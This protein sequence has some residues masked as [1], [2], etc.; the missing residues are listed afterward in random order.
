MRHKNAWNDVMPAVKY[1][2]CSGVMWLVACFVVVALLVAETG[3]LKIYN[4]LIKVVYRRFVE[5]D[6]VRLLWILF[7]F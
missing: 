5:L 3:L 7:R 6:S 1:V 4:Y 2:S